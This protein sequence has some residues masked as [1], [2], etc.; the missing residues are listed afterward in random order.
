MIVED[1][2]R[3]CAILVDYL[4]EHK[5]DCVV[6]KDGIC[7]LSEFSTQKPDLLLLDLMLPNLDGF[8]ICQLIR[9]MS[10]VPIVILTAKGDEIDKLKGYEFGADDYVTKPFSP[11]VIVA[12]VNALLKRLENKH[13]TEIINI[14]FISI[15]M[16]KRE[17]SV[18][19]E[20]IELTYKEF[21]LLKYFMQNPGIVFT[22]EHFLNEIWGYEFT[23]ETRTVDT[24]IKTLRNKLG[25][26]GAYIVTMIRS[27]Y[28]FEER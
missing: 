17:V 20:I 23:G 3:L 16:L 5:H 21:E 22:R 1:D 12:K 28:K 26:A 6:V 10:N 27:G 15:N 19:G 11:K 7:V 2:E 4:T 13:K 18:S 9:T 25:S 8:K 14:G 24:H